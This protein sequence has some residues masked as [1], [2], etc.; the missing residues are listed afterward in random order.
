MAQSLEPWSDSGYRT[1]PCKVSLQGCWLEIIF[2]CVL[3]LQ[4]SGQWVWTKKMVWIKL[5]CLMYVW[6]DLLDW[7]LDYSACAF[8]SCQLSFL[9][10]GQSSGKK[11]AMWHIARIFSIIKSGVVFAKGHPSFLAPLKI[12]PDYLSFWNI[13]I[14]SLPSGWVLMAAHQHTIY[15]IKHLWKKMIPL[16]S[17]MIFPEM[18]CLSHFSLSFFLFLDLGGSVT[19]VE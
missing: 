5:M 3:M 17:Q 6:E 9:V 14:Q 16:S 12:Q 10:N 2:Y 4:M 11:S 1:Q 18:K 13:I 15:D 7:L 19:C 8:L